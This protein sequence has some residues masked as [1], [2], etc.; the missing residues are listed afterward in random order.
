VG[1]LF[2]ASGPLWVDVR[3]DFHYVTMDETRFGV[4]SIQYLGLLAGFVYSFGG[5]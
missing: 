1:G 3:G 4:S 2:R 5:P